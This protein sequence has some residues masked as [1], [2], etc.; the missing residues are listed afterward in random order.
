MRR[1]ISSYAKTYEGSYRAKSC[2]YRAISAGFRANDALFRAVSFAN[3]A[4]SWRIVRKRGNEGDDYPA[5]LSSYLAAGATGA[6]GA[7]K[8]KPFKGSRIDTTAAITSSTPD[9]PKATQC[10]PKRSKAQPPSQELS[11]APTW[12]PR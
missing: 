8:V 1:H 5:H 7:I 3:R 6:I 9:R 10:V 4:L 11:M 12:C 2:G